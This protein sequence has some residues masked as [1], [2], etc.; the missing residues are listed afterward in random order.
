MFDLDGTLINTIP[1]IRWT[2]ERVFEHFE[3]PWDPEVM[4]TV[5]L[6]LREI[7]AR[8][9]PGRAEE[10]V[11]T[12]AAIQKTKYREMTTVYP[13]TRRT[14]A[15]I[16][17]AGRRTAVVTSKRREPALAGMAIT[18]IDR[19]IELAVAV[20][21]VTRGKPDPEPVNKALDL[22]QTRPPEAVYIGDSWYDILAGRQ[23]GVTT[24]AVTWGMASRE[25]LAEHR[26]DYIIDSWT[27]F[28][29]ILR[30]MGGL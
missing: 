14:L 19:Y 4:Q 3:L 20:E 23:A 12:Y 6:P 22:L 7:A 30:Q 15:S 26:P 17:T 25:Q 24:V 1:L 5:G 2:F 21:D 13:G 29:A 9:L 8:Y 18:G 11:E 28:H 27:D 10:F 16:R